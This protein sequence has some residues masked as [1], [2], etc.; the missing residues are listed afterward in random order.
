MLETYALKARVETSSTDSYTFR[1]KQ[2]SS[3][4]SVELATHRHSPSKTGGSTL[5]PQGIYAIV[6]SA[7]LNGVEVD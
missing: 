1:Y 2:F 7:G 3:R 5:H 6:F 4:T